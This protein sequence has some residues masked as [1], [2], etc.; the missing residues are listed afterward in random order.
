MDSWQCDYCAAERLIWR[1]FLKEGKRL[2]DQIVYEGIGREDYGDT[3]ALLLLVYKSLLKTYGAG[4][5][6]V[7]WVMEFHKIPNIGSLVWIEFTVR[8]IENLGFAIV[9]ILARQPDGSPLMT[10]RYVTQLK[11]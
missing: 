4:G 5:T 9:H 10:V 11:K 8:N 1:F 6:I 7:E 2:F 3:G